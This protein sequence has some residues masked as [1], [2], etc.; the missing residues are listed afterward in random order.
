LWFFKDLQNLQLAQIFVLLS[1]SFKLFKAKLA[2]ARLEFW[3]SPFCS[4]I[5]QFWFDFLHSLRLPEQ[6]N[7]KQSLITS[8][9]L[10]IVKIWFKMLFN[11]IYCV[12]SCKISLIKWHIIQ[13]VKT[14]FKEMTWQIFKYHLI[15]FKPNLK[16]L[17]L[18][19]WTML[20]WEFQNPS[21]LVKKHDLVLL[22]TVSYHLIVFV[23]QSHPCLKQNTC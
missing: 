11:T 17:N 23:Y 13:K 7:S 18:I 1:D 20:K 16:N 5:I 19:H 4:C 21:G 6:N 22:N 12:K 9:H 15:F 14:A 8:F 2:W 3:P 10:S